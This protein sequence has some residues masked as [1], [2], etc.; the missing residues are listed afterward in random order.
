[1]EIE[2]AMP[3]AEPTKKQSGER[4]DP[5][6]II[7]ESRS[8]FKTQDSGDREIHGEF[9][10]G[11]YNTVLVTHLVTSKH[12]W[13]SLHQSPTPTLGGM[14]SNPAIYLNRPMIEQLEILSINRSEPCAFGFLVEFRSIEMN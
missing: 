4:I 8:G 2:N 5:I 12:S 11:T 3:L 9:L 7:H 10:P 6:R 14:L 1:M 13:A